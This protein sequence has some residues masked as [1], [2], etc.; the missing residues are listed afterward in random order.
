MN[1]NEEEMEVIAIFLSNNWADFFRESQEFM[2][3][4]AL[5]RLAEK[6]KLNEP[7]QVHD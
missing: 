4:V 1:L 2:S 7:K 6:F 3:I 5:H